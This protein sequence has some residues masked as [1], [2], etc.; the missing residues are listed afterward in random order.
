M[1]IRGA[2]FVDGDQ[3][4]PCSQYNYGET[5]DYDITIA[6]PPACPSAGLVVSTT[7]TQNTAT[8]SWLLTCSTASVFD[9]EFGPVG[10]VQGTGTLLNNQTVSISGDTATFAF[11][12]LIDNTDYTFYY[13]ANCGSES[14]LWSAVNNFTTLCSSITA[15]G[16]CEGFDSNSQTE[17]CWTILHSSNFASSWDTNTDFN[18]LNGDN[19]ASISTDFNNSNQDEWL[20]TPKLTLNGTEIL[21][22]NYQVI[23][24]LEVNDLKIK[25]STTGMN[26][27]DFTTTLLSLDSI[28]NTTY[29]DTSVNLTNY[30][31]NVYIAFHIPNYTTTFWMLFLDQICITECVPANI[32][33]DSLQ[34]CQTADSLDLTTVLNIGQSQGNWSLNSNPTALSGSTLYLDSLTTGVYGINYL[35]NDACQSTAATATIFMYE[36]SNAGVDSAVI[37]CKGQPFD[38]FDALTGTFQTGGTWY[39]PNNQALT[40][41]F[42]VTG[43]F[44]GQFNYDYIMINGVCPSDSSNALLIVN[45]CI[46]IGMDE[47]DYNSVTIYPNPASDWLNIE[48]NGLVGNMIVMDASG[49]VLSR[50]NLAPESQSFNFQISNIEKGVYWLVLENGNSRIVKPWIKN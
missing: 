46:Y 41:S 19:C 42:I 16:W 47:L 39:D 36:P 44:P 26:P 45:D 14:S 3:I 8:V 20:I 13:R 21:K 22:F 23:S 37:L 34:I 1:R 6:A 38:L 5:E 11:V 4:D 17:Q 9:F 12:G 2:Y 40:N 7:T 43:N 10:F 49:R 15:L 30:I 24:D 18:Q 48:W 25:I 27:A 28:S 50:F 31:G 32:T 33:D 35:V 29:Q